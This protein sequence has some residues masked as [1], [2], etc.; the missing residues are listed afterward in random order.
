MGFWTFKRQLIAGF[1]A[2]GAGLIIAFTISVKNTHQLVATFRTV[3][4]TQEVLGELEALQAAM[5]DAETGVRGYLITGQ[6]P[7]LEPFY[8]SQT[9]VDAHLDNL[10]SL[11]ADN[12]EQQ[13]RLASLDTEIKAQVEYRKG[14]VDTANAL[15]IETGRKIVMDGAGKVGMDK[16]RQLIGEMRHEEKRLLR[17]RQEASVRS[18]HDASRILNILRAFMLSVL[19]GAYLVI[20]REMK[21][22]HHA[23]QNLQAL[24]DELEL[25]VRFRT[26]ELETARN[27]LQDSE[28]R[29]QTSMDNLSE[30]VVVSDMEGRLLHFNRA[31]L[32]LHEFTTQ[33]ESQIHLSDFTRLIEFSTL[34]GETI[35]IDRWPL[36]R[37]L[38]GETLHNQEVSVR[39]L[40][41]GWMR[42]FSYNGSLARDADG[43][44]LLAVVTMIDVTERKKSELKIITQ[45]Q[46]LNL[47]DQ[48]TRLI[49]DRLDLQ[50]IFQVVIRSL[51]ENLPVDF[52]CIARLDAVSN[53]LTISR[54]GIKNH[55]LTDKFTL[56]ENEA[57]AVDDNGLGRCTRGEFVYE[58]DISEAPYPFTKLLAR[59]G[60]LSVAMAPLRSESRVFGVLIVARKNPSAFSSGECEFLRQ[61]SEHVALAAWHAQLH[62]AL[63]Q[64][65]EDLRQTQQV[66]MQEERLRALGQMASGIAHDI[67]NALS[68]VSLY[69]ESLLENEQ[70]LSPRARN[71][72][73]TIHRSVD[74]V[75]QTVARM[76]EFYR[77]RETQLELSPVN[78]N[79]LVCQVLDLTRA[80]WQAMPQEHGIVINVKTQLQEKLPV[81]MGRENEIREALTNLVLNAV[82]AMPHGG[83]LVLR[84]QLLKT[85]SQ[86]GADMVSIE[87]TDNG[88]GMDEATRQRCLE[89]FFTTKGERGTGLG[90]AMVFGMVQRHSAD[91]K[92][93]SVPGEGTTVRLSFVAPS[94]V[95]KH[96]DALSSLAP[97]LPLRLLLI[98]DD[99]ILLKSLCDA[100]EGDGHAIVCAN[101]GEQG[102]SIFSACVQQGKPFD[103]VIT[104]LGMPY[105]DGH[106]VA[107]SIKE[108]SST[109]PVIL[110]TGW[111]QRMIA[112]GALPA[113]VDLVLAKPPKLRELREALIM[114]G[115]KKV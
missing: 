62:A 56:T 23:E 16:I 70:N 73:E 10:K 100:L 49:G 102:I 82:D 83:T 45:L 3:A 5:V 19:G 14:L 8:I 9:A 59:S 37:V 74:D 47:L 46:H 39:H 26:S 66:I 71:Y 58:P 79:P 11:T 40:Q 57:I 101:G 87:V 65:Y 103:I 1:I 99:P 72:L 84:T 53:T 67:N 77:Q 34:G 93:D 108:H 50:S 69:T 68:P 114:L 86:T 78:V 42:I 97:S 88:T 31:A 30:G 41:A 89:P 55:V 28:A 81:I 18:D 95:D 85:N 44:P 60:L 27:A 115:A 15:G 32:L 13:N 80:R 48:I 38:Q 106:K 22:R 111:G 29:L 75:A 64:A 92:I 61:L 54:V 36:S 17:V 35:P 94:A 112:E 91:L 25:R 33:E 12:P 76:R 107:A 105:T 51:E 6:K 7:Y 98:D 43:D 96:H 2:V 20:I 21:L 110:L 52:G 104:D 90:L 4:H 24:N 63:T 113:N 109:T